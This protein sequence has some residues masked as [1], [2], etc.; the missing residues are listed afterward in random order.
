MI[1]HTFDLART[2]AALSKLGV[3]EAEAQ[4]YAQMAGALIYADPVRRAASSVLLANR[5]GQS[6]LWKY[7]I[8]GDIPIVLMRISDPARVQIAKQLIQAHSYWRMKGL[9]ADLVILTEKHPESS[10][11]LFDQIVSLIAPERRA[12]TLD[13]PGGIFIRRLDQFSN[14][15]LVLL[16]SAARIVLTDETRQLGEQPEGDE[17][18]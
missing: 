2:D 16:Q 14:E 10:Q 9:P 8:S 4:I 6:G 17:R 13:K 3:T 5:R 15:D 11:S 12:E 18:P 1:D 7:G